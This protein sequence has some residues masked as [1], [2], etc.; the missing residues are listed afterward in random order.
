MLQQQSHRRF[1]PQ[2]HV[3]I[4]VRPAQTN[5]R[6]EIPRD[7]LGVPLCILCHVALDQGNFAHRLNM[8]K[9]QWRNDQAAEPQRRQRSGNP[10]APHTRT[11]TCTCTRSRRGDH[12]RGPGNGI[13]STCRQHQLQQQHAAQ[14]NDG[15]D[16][17][18]AEQLRITRERRCQMA[19][20]QQQPGEARENPG[21]QP[22]E[23]QPQAGK[24][25]RGAHAARLKAPN[26]QRAQ[27]TV[28]QRHCRN[29]Q[30]NKHARQRHRGV[31]IGVD[32]D[33]DPGHAQPELAKTKHPAQ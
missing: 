5:I 1:R 15:R 24:A 19:I 9:A 12:R 33:V 11:R 13:G 14:H 4:H 2:Q 30:R 16:A 25:Q 10:P 6:V 22:I 26:K 21:E 3:D 17:V 28:K 31:P 29:K 18:H 23:Q 27:H 8:H 7:R 20:A 32:A